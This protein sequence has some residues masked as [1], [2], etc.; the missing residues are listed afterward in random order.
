MR[1][2][3][4]CGTANHLGKNRIMAKQVDNLGKLRVAFDLCI[5]QPTEF[6]R[7]FNPARRDVVTT[8]SQAVNL[9][10]RKNT[11]PG[12]ISVGSK[13]LNLVSREVRVFGAL[14]EISHD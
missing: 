10:V 2:P 3:A 7:K 5:G 12:D 14:R 9:F 6:L 8:P 4:E 11:W 13:E 1:Q